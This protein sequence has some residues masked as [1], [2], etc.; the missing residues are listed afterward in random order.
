MECRLDGQVA[1]VTGASSGLGRAVALLYGQSGAAVVVNYHRDAEGAAEVVRQIGQ[2]GGRALAVQADVAEEAAVEAL[3]DDAARHFGG[4]DILVAN[5][6]LQQD[7]PVAEMT[8]EQWRRVIDVNLTG[9]F[10]CARA[11]IRR[12]RAQG[13]RPGA[14]PSLGKIL[15]MSSVHEVIPWAGRVNYAASKGGVA[16]LMR[17]LAQEVAAE[18]IR[19]NAIAPGAI[20]TPINAENTEGEAG[21]KLLS[22]IPYGRIGTPEDVARAALFLASD[23]ADY[24][25]GATLFVDGGMTLY[26]AFR[27]NG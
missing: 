22:L 18:G 14:A 16:L 1:V 12:F 21:E 17:S 8:L 10:L 2:A 6:G 9:Q 20:R 5:S 4:I 13:R 27:D 7:A 3:F 19:V 26:P 15:C 23:M 24:V 25:V 11:A